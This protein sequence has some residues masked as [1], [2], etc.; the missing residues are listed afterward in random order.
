MNRQQQLAICKA[1]LDGEE[2]QILDETGQDSVWKDVDDSRCNP[3]TMPQRTF[4]VKPPE[5]QNAYLDWV[6]SNDVLDTTETEQAFKAGWEEAR[7][8][9]G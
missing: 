7:K 1:V 8:R 6:N 4:R 3:I 5:W 2:I 9:H